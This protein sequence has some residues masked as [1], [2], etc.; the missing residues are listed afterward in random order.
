MDKLKE[1][2]N[3]EELFIFPK[4]VAEILHVSP[5]LI[6]EKAKNGTLEYKCV[7]SGSRTYIVRKSFLEY[8]EVI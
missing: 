5:Q 1:I 8:L 7:R 3:S 2:L 4:D 6:R